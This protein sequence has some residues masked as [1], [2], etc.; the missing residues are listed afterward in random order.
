L[1]WGNQSDG[2]K[3]GEPK[4]PWGK[5]PSGGGVRP[6]DF[7]ELLKRAQ[8]SLSRYVPLGALG[9]GGLTVAILAVIGLWIAS[10]IYIV[11]PYEQGVVLRFGRFVAHTGPGWNYHL[12]WPIE[13]AYTPEVTRQVE[14][15]IGFKPSSDSS[16][17]NQPEDVPEES[18]M[19]TGD[20]NVVDLH[21]A[22]FW[23]IKDANA[24]LFNVDHPDA[25]L[26]AVAESA[27]REVVGEERMEQIATSDRGAIQQKVLQSIQRTLDSYGAGIQVNDV[28]MLKAE[29]PIE[30]RAATLDV[31]AAL[32]DED[33]K[34]ND[35]E[36][37]A[38][39]VIPEARG[40]AAHIV[41]DA[42][43]YR[44]QAIAEAEGQ[45][46]RFLA[47]D[48]E[49]KKAPAVTKQ[50]LWLQTMSDVLGPA[51]KVIVDDAAKGAT[52]QL[53]P[54]PK[55]SPPQTPQAK[56]AGQSPG[57]SPDEGENP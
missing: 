9:R 25:A 36:T 50:L 1:P 46:Q 14:T 52:I 30:V 15:D 5:P 4:G 38:N 10:G 24:Y 37:Y 42:D 18:L 43:A 23:Q 22:V 47:V 6:P 7:E 48:A 54:M 21:F 29:P 53:P 34:K 19:L 45:S 26:K 3:G 44:Q 41:Q 8:D 13:S 40:D 56:D 32:S 20:E 57:Q 27:M 12:P 51:N 35:A 16:T 55:P 33:K 49:Y 2:Q 28:K 31:Q 11:S 39:T 17:P